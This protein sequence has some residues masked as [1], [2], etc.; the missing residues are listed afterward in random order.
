MTTGR[1][2]F[3]TKVHKGLRASLFQLSQRAAASDYADA[4][5]LA[6]LRASSDF[7]S[8]MSRANFFEPV[9]LV[10]SPVIKKPASGPMMS[11]TEPLNVEYRGPSGMAR[12]L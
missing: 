8:L 1:I 3:Y 12:G 6:T 2:D 11:G 10:R 4:Q 7:C 9:T 5:V